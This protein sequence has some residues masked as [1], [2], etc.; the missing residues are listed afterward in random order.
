LLGND[1]LLGHGVRNLAHLGLP[2][3]RKTEGSFS[4]SAN[5]LDNKNSW[6]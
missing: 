6:L 5:K 1:D 2:R 4:C 3:D